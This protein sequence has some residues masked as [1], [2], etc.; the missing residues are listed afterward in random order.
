VYTS[1]QG[2]AA[3]CTFTL[4]R[5]HFL[6]EQA[7]LEAGIPHTFLRDSLYQD[8]LPYFPG[9]D[10]VIRAPAGTGRLAAVARD[11]VAEVAAISLLDPAAHHDQAY[12]MT[13]PEALT[14]D[15]VATILSRHAPLP[16][17]YEAETVEEAYA[18]RAH[19]GAPDFEVEGWVTSYT[20]I[21]EGEMAPLSD[22][23]ERLTGHPPLSL[24]AFLQQEPPTWPQLAADP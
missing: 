3:D 18:S 16:I 12:V 5:H 6:T 7:I 8:V 21:A 11:D 9:A 17:R 20:A 22:D 19:F 14:M 1:F 24:E 4:G 23:V 10:G 2:A 15:E 13:G